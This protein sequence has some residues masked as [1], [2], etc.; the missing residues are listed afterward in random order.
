MDGGHR[1]LGSTAVGDIDRDGIVDLAIASP[2]SHNVDP[3][4]LLFRGD[5]SGGFLPPSW[6]SLPSN[7]NPEGFR[8]LDITDDGILDM[9]SGGTVY[10]GNGT[11]KFQ[12]LPE[13]L[14]D[15]WVLA[16][17]NPHLLT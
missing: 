7:K 13:M 6:L 11:W 2:D 12:A 3:R 10:A 4:I 9:V 1:L 17:M 15:W 5:G 16:D 8:L 14:P